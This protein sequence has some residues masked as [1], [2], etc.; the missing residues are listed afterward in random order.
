MHACTKI[1]QD[2]TKENSFIGIYACMSRMKACAQV[3][4]PVRIKKGGPCMKGMS[5]VE[6]TSH[7]FF[8]YSPLW[9]SLLD[10]E[11]GEPGQERGGR[12]GSKNIPEL[13]N[14]LGSYV[15]SSSCTPTKYTEKQD[16][17]LLSSRRFETG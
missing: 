7:W 9:G 4:A 3:H 15:L 11:R 14:K 8:V 1:G 2:K 12:A 17:G 6:A 5:T 13:E 10:Y 16:V